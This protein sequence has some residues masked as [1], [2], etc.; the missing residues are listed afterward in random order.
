MNTE[1]ISVGSEIL[2]GSILN[3]NTQ[4]ITEKL[5]E[6]GFEVQK[7]STVG[8]DRKTLEE[9]FR[10]ALDSND[11]II[12]TGGLGPTQDDLTKEVIADVLD[13]E[14]E[15]RPELEQR[16]RDMFS[17]RNWRLTENNL[18]QAYLP[19]G[20]IAL[21]NPNGTATGI[22]I[23]KNDKHIFMLPGP[24]R[25]MKDVFNGPVMQK[26]Q[27]FIQLSSEPRYYHISGLGESMVEDRIM[28]LVLNEDKINLATYA[29]PGEVLIKMSTAEKEAE[30][31]LNEYEAVILER[32]GK[33]IFSLSSTSLAETVADYL[34]KEHLT[35][36]TAESCTGGMISS[37]LAGIPGI[38]D[39]LLLGVVSYSNEAKIRVLKV[40]EET[41]K[42]YGA[43][44]EQ[45]C[46]EMCE[47]VR[48]ILNSDIGVSV[49][50][51][52]GPGGGSKEKPVGLVYTGISTKN[53]TKVQKNLFHGSRQDI[54]ER[55]MNMVF[56]MIR[57]EFNIS[58]N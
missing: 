19:A 37:T 49:T 11:I 36:S 4:F 46:R 51:I 8:D 28:D 47:N 12:L 52:A 39:S 53:G 35:I 42:N 20:S 50:G 26:L 56:Q 31:V 21:D 15:F 45:T 55:S 44:S 3:T 13:L 57:N 10:K 6:N 18:R 17:A 27:N 30:E 2:S 24:P 1:I 25:E 16:L 54:R 14:L 23:N 32:L 41:L 58:F 33:Y 22:Y 7:H 34:I 5:T 9:T 29:K 48:K 43:V 40:K 38:S